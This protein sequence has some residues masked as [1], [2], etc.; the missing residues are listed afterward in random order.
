[1]LAKVSILG[2]EYFEEL[3]AHHREMTDADAWH[4]STASESIICP[5]TTRN[6]PT[7]IS[8]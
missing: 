8:E 3:L 1:L 5:K 6:E 2:P 7:S 4:N